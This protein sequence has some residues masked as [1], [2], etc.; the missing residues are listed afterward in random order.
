[1]LFLQ[2]FDIKWGVEWGINMGL[3]NALSRKD[4]VDT[5]DDN[6]EITMLKG[7]NL[8]HHICAI[9]SALAKKIA[10]SSTL[11]PIVIKA[12]V[13]MNEETGEPWIPWTT[14][15]DWEFMDGMLYFKHQLYIPELACHNLV[16]SLHELSTRQHEA[17]F[18]TLH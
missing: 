9:D 2:D 5:D 18:H 11:D 16:K 10:A 17:F 15:T 4:E 7:D 6:R 12:L 1:M 8:Y 3:A 13:A 14:K